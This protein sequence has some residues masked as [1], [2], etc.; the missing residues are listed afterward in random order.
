MKYN[1]HK[2]NIA[3]LRIRGAEPYDN[4]IIYVIKKVNRPNVVFLDVEVRSQM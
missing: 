2:N 4:M 3:T 1:T